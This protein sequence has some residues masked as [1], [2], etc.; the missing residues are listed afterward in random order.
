MG[1]DFRTEWD[2]PPNPKYDLW[3]ITNASEIVPGVVTPLLATYSA[4]AEYGAYRLIVS[5]YL[6]DG[7]VRIYKNKPNFAGFFAGRIALNMGLS[8]ALLSLV[9]PAIGE[10]VLG[11]VFTGV[12]GTDAYIAKSTEASRAATAANLDKIRANAESALDKHR[13]RLY[14]ERAGTRYARDLKL[15]PDKAFARQVQLTDEAIELFRVH[16]HVSLAAAE[17]QV[18][19][20]GV[21]DMIGQPPE[22]VVP[23]CSGLGEVESSKPAI[24]L[25]DLAQIASKKPKVVAALHAGDHDAVLADAAFARAFAQFLFDWGYR[26]QG[27]Y[28]ASTPDWNENPT[29]ALSQVRTMLGVG[30][31]RSPRGLLAAAAAERAALEDA[32]RAAAPPDLAPVL[33]VIMGEAQ[34]FTRLR[35][36]SKAMW[37]LGQRRGRA[38]YLAMA[39][40]FAATGVTDERDDL[41][42]CF[43][44]EVAKLAEGGKVAG[45]RQK[46]ERRRQ[47]FDDAANYVLPDL[48]VGEPEV[49]KIVTASGGEELTGLGVSAGV[50]TGRA[51]IV[52][53]V[54]AAADR[55]IEPGEILVAPF[56]DAPWTPLFIPAGAVVVETGG[57]LSHAATVAREF[58]IPCVVMVKGATS[59]IADGDLV[60][61]DG[62]AGTVRILER[63]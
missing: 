50:A 11:Q 26:V 45:L 8:A 59:L 13:A 44:D 33:D 14:K 28:D 17:Y 57:V 18:K 39:D 31:E 9:D 25:W 41:R 42:F 6:G 49:A 51:R 54:L 30:A 58:G 22:L 37:M 32:V 63:S 46:I 35:E 36:Y 56:T 4:H 40:H 1:S 48:W 2:S 24:A 19:L 3:T 5:D 38:V 47:Q 7:R 27:E 16:L 53:D 43:Y 10:A 61:V 15:P 55:D 60:E 34:R 21:L 23:L 20:G 52:A 12:E 62:M 29:F